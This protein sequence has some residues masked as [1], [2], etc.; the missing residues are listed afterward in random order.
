M[1]GNA[2]PPAIDTFSINQTF[3]A[4]ML[5]ASCGFP[6]T[7]Q[8]EGTLTVK[9]FVDSSGNF[10]RELD[11]YHLVNSFTA[12]GHTITGRTSQQI[13]TKLLPDGSYTVAFDGTDTILTLPGGGVVFGNVGRLVLLF[14]ADNVLLEVVQETGQSFSNTDAICAALAP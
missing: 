2:T 7:G 1:T 13:Q 5:T 11:T 8:I 3:P 12:N 9:T 10:I 14:S 4:R 6:V